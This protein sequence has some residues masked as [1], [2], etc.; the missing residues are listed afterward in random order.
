MDP[1]RF[2]IDWLLEGGPTWGI[3]QGNSILL[4]SKTVTQSVGYAF[5]RQQ[6]NV[7]TGFVISFN[8]SA[9]EKGEGF[10]FVIQRDAI[11]NLNGGTGGNLGFRNFQNALGIV[12]DFCTDRDTNIENPNCNNLEVSM[13]FVVGGG[14]VNASN[15]STQL[16]APMYFPVVPNNGLT[17]TVLIRYF[18]EFPPWFEVYMD[19][20]LFLQHRNIN[21]NDV[22]G[23]SN[24]FVGFTASTGYTASDIIIS[25]FEVSAVAIEDSKTKS[26]G[27][28]NA[29]LDEPPLNATADGFHNISFYFKNY[30]LCGNPI[31]FGGFSS[32]AFGILYSTNAHEQNITNTTVSPST[33]TGRLLESSR[34]PPLSPAP[35]TMIYADIVDQADGTYEVRFTTI[36]PG[37]YS[38]EMYWG[39]ACFENGTSNS[40]VLTNPGPNCVQVSAPNVAIFTPLPNPTQPPNGNPGELPTAALTG[41]GVAVSAVSCVGGALI[42]AGIRVRNRWRKDK[43]FIDAGKIAA[44]ERGVEYLGDNE[45]DILQNKL[46]ATLHAIHAERAKKDSSDNNQREIEELLHQRGELQEMIRRMK[47][48]KIGLDPDEE[49][50]LFSRAVRKSFAASRASVSRR[51]SQGFLSGQTL[52]SS[53]PLFRLSI[54]R[55]SIARTAPVELNSYL[56]PETENIWLFTHD[57]TM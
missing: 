51:I 32:R 15:S 44:A 26:V 24:A 12:F 16:Y 20:D 41:I 45:L 8:F 49:P 43:A 52:E 53:N 10:V 5:L 37:T 57:G 35:T 48:R 50:I 7:G 6:V 25:D 1:K 3:P 22:I 21:L 39:V 19:N 56:L 23:G 18:A 46:Q 14:P 29:T 40:S 11:V 33:R 4:T 55:K 27:I 28:P 17:H 30:D 2:T 36:L 38:L 54:S 31:E 9:S 13:H 42:L 34:S 47:E